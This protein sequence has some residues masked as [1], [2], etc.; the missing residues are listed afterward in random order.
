MK[1]LL[2]LPLLMLVAL[3]DAALAQGTNP[4][5]INCPANLTNWVCGVASTATVFY[6]P[7]T[8]TAGCPTNAVVTCSPPSGALFPLGSTTVTC[9]ATNACGESAVCTFTVT[10]A[11]DTT[12]PVIQCPTN[13]IVWLCGT[14][15]S[16]A[17]VSW[18]PPVATDNA[19]TSVLIVCSPASG[20]S[21]QLGTTTVTCTATDNCT[22]RTTCT[23]TVTV[24]RDTQPPSMDCPPD[25]NVTA[26]ASTGAIVNYPTPTATDNAD[27]SVSVVCSPASG[28]VFPL[29]N[30][31]VTC[32]ATD[33]CTNKT[34]CTFVVRVTRDTTPPSITC[35][36]NRVVVLCGTAASISVS[37]PPP[38]VSDNLDTNV[39]VTCV[40]AS[41]SSFP[42]GT[43]TVVCTATDDCGNTRSCSFTVTVL[44]DITP[45]VITCPSNIVLSCLCPGQ[46]IILDFFQ[47]TATDD[48]DPSPVVV[49]DPPSLVSSPGVHPVT[50]T[51]TDRCGNSAGC[52]FT[53]TFQP[54]TTPP[55]IQCPTNIITSTC[56]NYAEVRYQVSATDTCGT[57][58][59]LVC[60]PPSGSPFP[61]GVTTV[62]CK[63]TDRC[64]NTSVCTFTV[65]VKSDATPQL[66]I[67]PND[68][69][70]TAHDLGSPQFALVVGRISVAGDTDYFRFTAPPNARAWIT[71][72]TGGQQWAGANSRNSAVALLN[73]GGAVIESDDNDGSGNGAN[74]TLESGDASAIAGAL[75]GGGTFYV[76][77]TA[78]AV[79]DIIAPY[80]LYLNVTTNHAP[81]EAEPNNTFLQANAVVIPSVPIATRGGVLTPGDQDWF[82]FGIPGPSILHL[83]VDGDPE[84]DGTGTDVVLELFRPDGVSLLFSANS[85]AAGASVAEGFPYRLSLGGTYYVRVRGATTAVAGT[86]RLMIATCPG[87]P[88]LPL[89]GAKLGA[90]G[91]SLSWPAASESSRLLATSDLRIWREIAVT[92]VFDGDR[93]IADLPTDPPHQF[94]LLSP[95]GGTANDTYHCCDANG[96]NCSEPMDSLT[97]CTGSFKVRCY[98]TDNSTVCEPAP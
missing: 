39:T 48:L 88:E 2:F 25:M 12:P 3:A 50:C 79:G 51:A 72:D 70:A 40:P 49:C 84:R 78:A 54:D 97:I 98:Q 36:T 31:T 65:R 71:V 56:S 5:R 74:S 22:N 86:Y 55:V 27:F 77:V 68:A 8:T 32:T 64:T 59:T 94:F 44:R 81:I 24:A 75:L 63:A 16:S 61:L 7:P 91:F 58:V 37:F 20:S 60:E 46:V 23:F 85:S 4:L 30:T 80:R 26:C 69:L 66:E 9:R 95:S 47:A 83:S 1:K 15:A 76:R 45:P 89:V 28:S 34:T 67:E 6:P 18:P 96:L 43:N 92:P 38:M 33:N 29:G 73:A 53:V 62:T 17:V 41:G 87:R 42:P 82:A 90:N 52:T 21:F 10:V 93:L 19:D 57:N 14:A 35:P 11:R 13:R